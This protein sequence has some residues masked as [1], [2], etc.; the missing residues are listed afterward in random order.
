MEHLTTGEIAEALDRARAPEIG[1]IHSALDD[2]QIVGLSG[3]AESGKSKLLSLALAPRELDD[4]SAVVRINLDGVYSPRHLARRWLRAVARAT[5]GPIAFSHMVGLQREVWPG[6][7]RQADHAVRNVLQDHYATALGA[8][9]DRLRSKGGDED[10]ARALAATDRLVEMRPTLVAVDHLESP[11]LSGALDV[12]AL[13]WQLRATSQ[14]TPS[15]RI[16]LVCRPGAVELAADEDAAFYGDGTWLTIEPPTLDA[17]LRATPN[18]AD[19]QEV[20]GLTRGHFWATL[21]M[22]QRL[23]RDPDLSA[24]G[25]LAD[26]AIENLPLADRSLQHAGALHRLGPEILRGIANDVGPYQSIP[27]ALSRDVAAA[28]QRLELGGLAH[29]PERGVWR[30]INP[31]VEA[32]LRDPSAEFVK[33][34][35]SGDRP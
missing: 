19:I 34:A 4:S 30:V 27:D 13:L 15:L 20:Y 28:A 22:L 2:H 23:H 6:A 32:A 18:Q 26:L 17:W 14:R 29:H 16:A 3:A 8:R 33:N 25:A 21:R 24:A 9:S 11:E 5:A 35:G 31:L 1:A 10:I 12:R 7:T